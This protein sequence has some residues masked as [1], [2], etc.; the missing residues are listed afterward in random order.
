[1]KTCLLQLFV[2]A[3]VLLTGHGATR[4]SQLDAVA[5]KNQFIKELLL[6][7][8]DGLSTATLHQHLYEL[9]AD[10]KISTNDLW[11]AIEYFKIPVLPQLTGVDP[12]HLKIIEHLDTEL[13]HE[14]ASIAANE[15]HEEY[16]THETHKLYKKYHI[17][18]SWPKSIKK[19]TAKGFRKDPKYDL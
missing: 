10:K 1:M 2:L 9:Y 8:K 14:A 17:A 5:S 16:V 12:R 15:D 18:P 7:G 6:Q 19:R 13:R 11:D 3:N 4:H